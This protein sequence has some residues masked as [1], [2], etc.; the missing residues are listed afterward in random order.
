MAKKGVKSLLVQLIAGANIVTVVGLLATGYSYLIDPE[1]VSMACTWG[2]VFPLFLLL[3]TLFLVFWLFVYP[4]KA[5]I[6]ILAFILSYFPVRTYM[7]LNFPKDVPDDALKVMTYNV[8]GFHGLPGEEL[9][10][11][12]NAIVEYLC[13]EDCDIICMQEANE[14]W[15][16][17]GCRARLEK[18]YPYHH[19]DGRAGNYIA[20]YSKHKILK[21]ENI[22]YQSLANLS[23]AYTMQIGDSLVTV[24][25]NH[26]ET[27]NLSLSDR[28]KFHDMVKGHMNRD[29]LRSQSLTLKD[30]LTESALIRVPEAKAVAKYIEEHKDDKIILLGDFNDNPISYTH[31]TIAKHLTDCFISSGTG[32]GW[33]FSDNGMRV[34]I[35]NIM[36]SD[37]FVPVKCFV[38][39]RYKLSDHFP[40]VCWL[41]KAP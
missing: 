11:D 31:Y 30:K 27:N 28:E 3:N 17:E 26:L 4:R 41:K 18:K 9:E 33:S 6:P 24:I 15:L 13:E 14:S 1:K 35:D 22:E 29:S 20:I 19:A 5:W 10:R 40:L 16:S 12:E 21:S 2:L 37:D 38:D 7:G 23:I 8:L 36:C 34:R 32:F 25:N 39:T